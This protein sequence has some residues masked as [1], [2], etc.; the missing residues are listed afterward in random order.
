M[1]VL[2]ACLVYL[3]LASQALALSCLRPDVAR[4]FDNF[5]ATGLPYA[6]VRGTL[7]FDVAKLPQAGSKS[8]PPRLT[9]IQ[10]HL[11]G[12]SL[13]SSGFETSFDH[14][15]TLE[16]KCL[17]AWCGGAKPDADYLLF[18]ERSAAGYSV[19]LG[20]CGGSEFLNPSADALRRVQ[21][22]FNGGACVAE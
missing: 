8:P 19:N 4:S 1:K 16:V 12:Q 17:A 14:P 18:V 9:K 10:A 7:Q 3:S 13:T 21:Q 11:T 15:V 2:T 20:P 6:V 5:E 22:C